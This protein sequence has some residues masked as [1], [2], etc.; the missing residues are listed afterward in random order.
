M[1][2]PDWIYRQSAVL[3]YRLRDGDTEVLLITSRKGTRWVLPKGIV[4][5]ELTPWESAAKEGLEEAGVKGEVLEQ[6]FGNYSYKKW[7]GVCR[8]QVFLMKVTSE[9]DTWPEADIRRREWL[10][11]AVAAERVNER[12][13]GNLIR[14]VPH[15][16]VGYAGSGEGP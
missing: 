4:E 11:F 5:P 15:A 16:T 1:A 3:P 8:V 13:L 6:E 9:L 7:R 2:K 10:P 12:E 14:R